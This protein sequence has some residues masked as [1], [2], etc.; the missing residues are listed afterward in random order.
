MADVAKG[1]RASALERSAES[2]MEEGRANAPTNEVNG[3]GRTREGEKEPHVLSRA[4]LN[5]VSTIGGNEVTRVAIL[6]F[7]ALQLY[8]IGALQK[9]LVEVQHALLRDRREPKTDIDTM[10]QKYGKSVAC[11]FFETA[12]TG[13]IAST[14]GRG[15]K[16]RDPYPKHY[17]PAGRRLRVPGKHD[18]FQ[19]D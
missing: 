19:G 7:R 13:L 17:I 11:G 3:K 5:Q 10:I 9:E 12:S 4:L 1:S 14:S 18:R 2:E 6:S 16:L 8:R 15:A